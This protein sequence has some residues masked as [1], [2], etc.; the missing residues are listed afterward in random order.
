M[1]GALRR[2]AECLF[3]TFRGLKQVCIEGRGTDI[4]EQRIL[5]PLDGSRLAHRT[6]LVRTGTL[7]GR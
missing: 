7:T 4:M 3:L 5:V 6:L 2:V 1:Q